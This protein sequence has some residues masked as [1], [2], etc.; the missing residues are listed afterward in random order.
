MSVGNPAA[1]FVSNKVLVFFQGGL[2]P[3]CPVE[4]AAVENFDADQL[5][6]LFFAFSKNLIPWM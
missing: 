6:N 5:H 2:Y 4:V 3:A 1:P